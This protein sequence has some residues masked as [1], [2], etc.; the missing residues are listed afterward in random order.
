MSNMDILMKL[1]TVRYIHHIHKA[2]RAI[3]VN[4]RH[5]KL[6]KLYTTKMLVKEN[7][8]LMWISEPTCMSTG[9]SGLSAVISTWCY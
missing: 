3:I 4:L 2:D 6:V 7:V 1:E 5:T 9:R 8:E